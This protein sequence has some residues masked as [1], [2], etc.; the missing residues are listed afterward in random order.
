[1]NTGCEFYADA[2][3]EHAAGRLEAERAARVDAHLDA[4]AEC[5][6]ALHAVHAL[7]AAPLEV[8]AGLEDR[9]RAAVRRAAG[10]ASATADAQA[11][12]L[13]SRPRGR[14]PMRW[15]VWALPLAAAAA[16]VGIW[17]GVGPAGTGQPDNGSAALAALDEYEPYGAWPADGVIV[18]GDPLL[19][20]LSV[21]ELETLLRE[22]GS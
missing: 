7:R 10:A 1:M 2:L 15:R 17:I 13:A 4:C 21:E 22:M 9:V 8:P 12:A 3:V 5:R 14:S 20:E 11:P 6:D 19:S 18:A 16:V